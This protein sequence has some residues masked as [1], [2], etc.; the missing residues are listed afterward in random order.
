VDPGFQSENLISFKVVAPRVTGED[1]GRST[2]FFEGAVERFSNLVG[3]R[4]ASAINFLPFGGLG[5]ATGFTIEGRPEPAAGER[6]GTDVRVIMPGYF[7]TMGIPLL[8]GREFE[9]RDNNRETPLRFVV[10]QSFARRFFPDEEVL[11]RRIS[12]IMARENP[13]GEIIGVVG[14][15]KD[16]SLDKNAQAA[17]YYPH[18]YLS[19]GSM[20]ML[21]RADETPA[22]LAK[23]KDTIRALNS[24]QAVPEF[25]SMQLV[26]SETLTRP[27]FYMLL[28]MLFAGVAVAL[29][30]VGIYGVIS[31]AVTQRTHEIGLRMA[32]GARQA[33]VLK[34][35]VGHGALLAGAGI[36]IGLLAGV[37]VTRTMAA[38]LFEVQPHDP[39]TFG[40]VALMLALV[41][42]LAAY[43]PARRAARVDPMVALRHE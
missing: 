34:L 42:L 21:V 41:T 40:A 27:R 4:S 35:V 38:L 14:D 24:A 5:S 29:A 20:I 26:M 25:R 23:L 6:P 15:M 30:A 28:L 33:D 31:Y 36:V 32:L 2:R 17:V 3:V 22:L 7:R 9:N 13:M 43:I 10:N 12:V 1:N 16:V 19:S 11:G 37:A 8:R 39:L 18:A